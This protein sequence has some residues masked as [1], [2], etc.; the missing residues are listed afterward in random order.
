MI[1]NDRL[2]LIYRAGSHLAS[3]RA[4]LQ[5][6]SQQADAFR[7]LGYTVNSYTLDTLPKTLSTGKSKLLSTI[8]KFIFFYKVSSLPDYSN[9]THLYLRFSPFGLGLPFL[10]KKAKSLN[11]D[12]KI[13]MEFAT[14]PYMAEYPF[15]K[16]MLLKYFLRQESGIRAYIDCAVHVMPDVS[17]DGVKNKFISNGILPEEYSLRKLGETNGILRLIFTGSLRPCHGLD[18]LIKGMHGYAH[19]A[20]HNPKVK[21]KIIGDGPEEIPLKNLTKELKIEAL[22]EFAPWMSNEELSAFFDNADMA[23]GSLAMDRIGMNGSASLK[24]REYLCRG[25]PFFYGGEDQA[26]NHCPFLLSMPLEEKPVDIKRIID[27]Y[28][29]QINRNQTEVSTTLRHYAE[30]NLSWEKLFKNL[31]NQDL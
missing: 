13:Y 29:S 2:A 5:K 14:Y 10:L 12:I 4:I 23:V 7:S 27:F 22:V 3:D 16:R 20:R 18:R 15:W 24:H 17:L 25:I 30:N 6:M 8:S 19:E 31:L 9:L 26:L 28:K 1:Q 11:P 21:L